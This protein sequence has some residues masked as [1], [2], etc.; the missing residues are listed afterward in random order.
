MFGIGIPELVVIA[1]LFG[2]V[3]AAIMIIVSILTRNGKGRMGTSGLIYCTVC[4]KEN[5]GK[6]M[7][8]IRCG[9]VLRRFQPDDVVRQVEKP[10]PT[11][12]VPAI[13]V[14]IF[15]CLP[16]GIPAI[17]FAAQANGKLEAGDRTGAVESSKKAKMWCWIGFA[18]G[19]VFTVIYFL[20]MVMGVFFSRR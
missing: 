17:V 12:L 16:F 13:L 8:C 2:V 11:Y 14:T 9:N 3:A 1:V 6:N 4:G 18:V 7:H 19:L 15:C 10:V 5:D 20:F